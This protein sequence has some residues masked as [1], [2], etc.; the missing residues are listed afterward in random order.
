MFGM[1]NRSKISRADIYSEFSANHNVAD[2]EYFIGSIVVCPSQDDV[3]ELIDGQQ[4]LTTTYIFLV[5]A[6]VSPGRPQPR[7]LTVRIA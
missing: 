7:R 6:S 2:H 3:L 1:L 5:A 4:R